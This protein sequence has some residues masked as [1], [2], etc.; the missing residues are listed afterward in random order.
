MSDKG[1]SQLFGL[2]DEVF[3]P[4]RPGSNVITKRDVAGDYPWH[5]WGYISTRYCGILVVVLAP[6]R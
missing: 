2:P 5:T 4:R 3:I 1:V 6:W